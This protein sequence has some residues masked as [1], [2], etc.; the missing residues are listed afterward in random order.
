MDAFFAAIEE[1]DKPRIKGRPIVV[2]ADPGEGKGRGVVSTANYA[3]RKFGIHSAMPISIAWRLSEE[4]KAKGETETVFLGVNSSLY[5]EVS[6]NIM[7]IIKKYSLKVEE[8]SVDEAYFEIQNQKVSWKRAKEIAIKIKTEIKNKEKLTCSI[9]IGPNKLVAKIASDLEKPNGLTVI[10][11]EDVDKIFNPLPIR[12]I[13]GIGPKVEQQFLRQGVNKV[14]DL[15]NLSLFDLRQL[16]GKWG[17][18]I[19]YKARGIDNSP[20]V[21]EYEVKSIGEQETFMEDARN[22]NFIMD[23]LSFL[24]DSVI[25][26]FRKSGFSGFR[27]IVITVRFDDFETKTRSYTLPQVLSAQSSLFEDKGLDLLKILNFEIVRMFLPF[28]DKRENPKRKSIRLIGVRV[29][30]FL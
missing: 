10:K 17:E 26:R 6:K 4:A 18:E 22:A 3:A 13:P 8:A 19:Y 15:K 29:E 20:I 9:G 21:L 16:L 27:T 23:R 24:C 2:G 28:I 30:K 5:E 1:R 14:S 25:K 7:A 11:E 12:K